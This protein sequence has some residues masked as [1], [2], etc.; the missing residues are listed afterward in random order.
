MMNTIDALDVEVSEVSRTDEK[1]PLIQRVYRYELHE[2]KFVGHPLFKLPFESGSEMIV[3][4][5]FRKVVETNR[6]RGLKFKELPRVREA[7]KRP[8]LF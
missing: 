1:I 7:L 5:E 3:D 8:S 4:D 2:E 6:L